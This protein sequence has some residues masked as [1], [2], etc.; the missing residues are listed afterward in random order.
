MQRSKK[1]LFDNL[2]RKRKQRCRNFEFKRLGGLE[3]NYQL[4]L[5]RLFH[6]YFGQERKNLMRLPN[7]PRMASL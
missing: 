3:I 2:I 4:E 7:T 6:R 1:E 5:S